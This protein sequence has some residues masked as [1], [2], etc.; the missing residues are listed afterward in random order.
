MMKRGE[1][2]FLP[3]PQSHPYVN[4]FKAVLSHG[5]CMRKACRGENGQMDHRSVTDRNAAWC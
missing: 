1:E 5:D 3:R 2:I 4:T